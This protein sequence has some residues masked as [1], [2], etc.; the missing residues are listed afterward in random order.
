[1][2]RLFIRIRGAHRAPSA[3]LATLAGVALLPSCNTLPVRE[4][5]VVAAPDGP[6][7]IYW[8]YVSSVETRTPEQRNEHLKAHEKAKRLPLSLDAEPGEY[9]WIVPVC[10][11]QT[12][13]DKGDEIQVPYDASP[14][15]VTC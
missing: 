6:K 7:R 12:R 2:A 8:T 3:I 1:M 13:W 15:R 4:V 10:G 5:S 14:V 9:L 11:G